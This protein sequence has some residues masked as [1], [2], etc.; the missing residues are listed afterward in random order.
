MEDTVL[1]F[2][3]AYIDVELAKGLL[4]NNNIPFLLK[5]QHGSGFVIRAGYVLEKY[6]LYVHRKDKDKAEEIL[7]VLK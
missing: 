4:E 7:A 3:G 6:Y 1:V 2:T 5:S